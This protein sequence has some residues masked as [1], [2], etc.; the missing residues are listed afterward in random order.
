MTYCVGMMLDKG[1]VLMS[2]TRTNSGVDNISVFRKM[3]HWSVP[4]ERMIALMTAGNLATTQAVIS[5]LEERNKAPA[6]RHNSV[7][8][9]PTMFQVATEVGRMLR[10]T[11]ASS[12]ESNGETAGPGTF[13]ASIIVAGQIKGMEPRLF[14]IYPEGNFI[15]AS[16]DTPFFQIGE[17]KY[18]RPII[19]R[20]YSRDM[21]F[22]DAVKLLM[23]SFDSTIKANLS[24]GLPLDLLVIENDR[25]EP[26]HQ[27]RIGKDN[28]YFH[29]I[30]VGWS[31]ALKLAFESLPDYTFF[32]PKDAG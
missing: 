21:S 20:G 14:L 1:L 26:A 16:F 30:S 18:G 2:D 11:I 9:A 25:F 4:G 17:T 12:D 32:M 6:E 5:Q 15:E 28:P 13:T 27:R 8:E 31:E 29:A 3:H 10:E 22:E 7:L 19:L 24:V 23:V